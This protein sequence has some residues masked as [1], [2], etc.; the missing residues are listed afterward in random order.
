MGSLWSFF[1]THQNNKINNNNCSS[2]LCDFFQGDGKQEILLCWLI[3]KPQIA[4][5]QP[6][7][8]TPFTL[9]VTPKKVILYTVA[10]LKILHNVI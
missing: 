5:H 1:K 4:V 6:C 9:P 2:S 8:L 7:N 10:T 3:P